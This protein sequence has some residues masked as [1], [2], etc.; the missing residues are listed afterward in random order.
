MMVVRSYDR[1]SLMY[2]VEYKVGCV[3]GSMNCKR[4]TGARSMVCALKRLERFEYASIFK[5]EVVSTYVNERIGSV[6]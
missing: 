6:R 2:V 3:Q 1:R 4:I 5:V